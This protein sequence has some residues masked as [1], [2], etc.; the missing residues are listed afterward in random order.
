MGCRRHMCKPTC[1]SSATHP[2]ISELKAWAQWRRLKVGW[3]VKVAGLSFMQTR[4]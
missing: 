1:I 3:V 2:E 4:T